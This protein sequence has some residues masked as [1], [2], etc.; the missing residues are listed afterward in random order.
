MNVLDSVFP[1]ICVSCRKEGSHL[2]EDCFSLVS[3]TNAVSPLTHSSLLSG[4]FAATSY[5]D[6]LIQKIIHN[7][8]YPPFLRDLSLPLASFILAHLALLDKPHGFNNPQGRSQSG[9][10]GY[11][12][13]PIPLHKKR[14]RWRGFNQAEK[15]AKQLSNILMM[16]LY[17]NI[18]V[19]TKHTAPQTGLS[20]EERETSVEGTFAVQKPDLVTN[21]KILLVDDVYTT[22]STME[23]ATKMLK[24]AG[25]IQVFGVVVARG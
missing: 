8:K 17:S 11:I 9:S 20:E 23:E 15:I 2:C 19:K 3:L 5:Q 16:P 12:L 6:V 14:L 13:I 25:A 1:K 22:G 7:Y 21:K 10:A 18:L 4:L 24:R